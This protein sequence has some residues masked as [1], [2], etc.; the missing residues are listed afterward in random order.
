MAEHAKCIEC[1]KRL[2]RGTVVETRDVAG[3]TF[4]AELPAE[5]CSACD[6]N[7]VDG[8]VLA[9]FESMVA[10][11]LAR[12]GRRTPDAFKF[13]RKALGLKATELAVLLAVTPETVSRW[14]NGGLQVE[15]RAFALLGGMAEDALAGRDATLARLRALQ[16]PA[17]VTEPV[18]LKVGG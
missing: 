2:K 1:G 8:E 15:P 12:L 16:E 7:Y 4:T 5:I 18:R 17:N 13:M 10:S 6:E 3:V 14:E 9:R 11:E